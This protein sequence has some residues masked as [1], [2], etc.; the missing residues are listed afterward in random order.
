MGLAPEMVKDG[1]KT[2]GASDSEGNVRSFLNFAR[3]FDCL[4]ADSFEEAEEKIHASMEIV[5]DEMEAADG[6]E[7]QQAYILSRAYRKLRGETQ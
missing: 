5:S 6:D 3:C 4:D 7:E 2:K 1:L